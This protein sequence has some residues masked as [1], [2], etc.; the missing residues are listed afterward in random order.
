M[1]I[2][3]ERFI[4]MVDVRLALNNMTDEPDDVPYIGRTHSETGD[5]D[6]MIADDCLYCVVPAFDGNPMKTTA[7]A[8]CKAGPIIRELMLECEKLEAFKKF[9]HDRLDSIGIPTDPESVHRDAGC[10]IGG[11]L[12][13]V[14]N[15]ISQLRGGR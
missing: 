4:E 9:V 15:L 8:I 11:R 10:R 1:T 3:K 7:E 12:D 13:I 6:V 2:S 5:I 14:E